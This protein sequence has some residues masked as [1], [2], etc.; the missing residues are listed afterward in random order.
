[1]EPLWSPAG[2]NRRQSVAN[3]TQ[4]KAR[5]QIAQH[6]RLHVA[7]I[8][9]A[10]QTP[11]GHI[12]NDTRGVSRRIAASLIRL[13]CG[14]NCVASDR[15]GKEGVDGSSPSEGSAKAQQTAILP[16][17]LTCALQYA[18]GVE[19]F[20]ELSGPEREGCQNLSSAPN[21]SFDTLQPTT[22]NVPSF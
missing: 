14:R 16:F 19:P 15:D 17:G 10:W 20:M 3:R 22:P 4:R 8:D 2:R 7:E 6:P 9:S 12:R 18:V 11:N 5:Q 1:M 13:I 21:P